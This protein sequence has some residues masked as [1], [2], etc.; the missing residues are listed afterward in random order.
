[1]TGRF[2]SNKEGSWIQ[3]APSKKLEISGGLPLNLYSA[4]GSW[5][6]GKDGYVVTVLHQ[7]HCVGM[8]NHVKL[9]LI[10]GNMPDEKNLAHMGHCIE[11]LRHGVMCYGDTALEKPVDHSNFVQVTTEETEHICRDWSYLS[12]QF[13]DVSIDFIWGTE[14]PMT[15]FENS[16][17]AKGDPAGETLTIHK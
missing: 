17:A 3:V 14:R 11:Y 13:W 15:V 7:L 16:D 9:G 5:P 2:W 12:E 4:N 6:N 10:H 1:M 8:L